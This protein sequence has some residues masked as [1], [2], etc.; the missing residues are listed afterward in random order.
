MRIKLTLGC[1]SSS[2]FSL[3]NGQITYPTTALCIIVKW[4][5]F[6]VFSDG[7]VT[8]ISCTSPCTFW[9]INQNFSKWQHLR[10]ID[11]SQKT[12]KFIGNTWKCIVSK[13][14]TSYSETKASS[15]GI[16]KIFF[17]L[18]GLDPPREEPSFSQESFITLETTLLGC[19]HPQLCRHSPFCFQ[20]SRNYKKQLYFSGPP[21]L[22][23]GREG[24]LTSCL[25]LPAFLLVSS[26]VSLS[27]WLHCL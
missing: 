12:K 16:S 1:T 24:R 9:K 17:D 2:D 20:I 5:P 4:T 18:N 8:Q 26:V 15:V 19:A 3:L 21:T 7:K 10:F 11:F 13:G 23:P 27:L 25:F 6:V 22:C 14:L